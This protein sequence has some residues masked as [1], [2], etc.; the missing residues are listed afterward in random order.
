MSHYKQSLLA[1]KQR[2]KAMMAFNIQ[3]VYHLRAVSEIAQT[4]RVPIIAQVSAKYIPFFEDIY[5]LAR[6]VKKFQ[7]EYLFFH[8]D[9]CMDETVIHQCIDAG[10]AGVMFDGSSLPITENICR[11][12][13]VY[14][15]ASE[16]GAL[17]EAELG[18]IQG[19]E[20]GF[21]V[22]DERVYSKEELKL[23]VKEASFDLLAMRMVSI[24][25]LRVFD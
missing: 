3:N 1:L 12:N 15:Y 19:V 24:R 18:A 4:K 11:T 23:F 7:S 10:F 2:T 21:G 13:D 5:G 17:V 25:Q 9:H 6:L 14:R 8:L 22:E 20:D 16:R